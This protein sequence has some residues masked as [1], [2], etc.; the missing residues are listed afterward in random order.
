M[1]PDVSFV[2]D[3][4]QQDLTKRVV[5]RTT[6]E[7]YEPVYIF[8]DIAIKGVIQVARP[9]TLTAANI[10]TSLRYIIVHTKVDVG[11]GEYLI[12][13]GVSYKVIECGNWSDAGY[14]RVVAEQAK[15][16]LA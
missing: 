1:L 15:D 6:D 12:D 2:L 4:W 11:V 9:E 16:A 3:Q 10:D 5:T 7:N 14:Y 13:R 8:T